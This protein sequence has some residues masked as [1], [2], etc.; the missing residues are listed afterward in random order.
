VKPYYQDSAVT[1]YHGDSLEIRSGLEY[2]A[3]LSDPPWGSKTA[4]NAQ[5]FTRTNS[6]WW[7]NVDNSKVVAH[8]DITGDA[9]PFDPSPWVDRPAILWGANHYAS[10]LQD[11]GG[12]LIWDK[13]D[14]AEDLAAKG[15]PLGEAELAWT[16]VR[17]S[18]RVFR[19]LWVGLL[20]SS[21]RGDFYHP[22]QK[23]T[24]LMRWC[25]EFLPAGLILDPFMGSGTT[26]RA[27][28]DLGRKAIGIEIEERYCEIA[29]KR[30]SQECLPLAPRVQPVQLVM[31]ESRKGPA[32]ED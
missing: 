26:L 8:Q 25:A 31:A 1:I 10:R 4:C 27:A 19:N 12:W 30:M 17:G 2:Q 23:P 11:S 28:K 21:E 16:N 5:R 3:I 6:P 13:R 9:K 32:R 14:G 24:S 15:W 22:T 18:T 29:A 7:T 20:R